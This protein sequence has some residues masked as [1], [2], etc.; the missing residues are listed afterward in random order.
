MKNSELISI[1]IPVYNRE[2]FLPEAI[3]SV[4]QQSAENWELIVV[5]DG[6]EDNTF[7]IAEKFAAQDERIRAIK[8]EREPKGAPV[9]RNIGAEA[10]KGNYLIFL[11][12]DDILAPWCIAQRSKA[13]REY[14]GYDLLAF[15]TLIFRYK[16]DDLRVL[17]NIKTTERELYRFI[18]NDCVWHTMGGIWRKEVFFEIG[19]FDEKLARWQDM[20]LHTRALA[21][22]ISYLYLDEELETPDSFYRVHHENAISQSPKIDEAHIREKFLI[23]KKVEEATKPLNKDKQVFQALRGLSFQVLREAIDHQHIQFCYEFVN[24]AEGRSC[25]AEDVEQILTVIQHYDPDQSV[26]TEHATEAS[27][28]LNKNLMGNYSGSTKIYNDELPLGGDCATEKEHINKLQV[29]NKNAFIESRLEKVGWYSKSYYQDG[30]EEIIINRLPEDGF[31]AVFTSVSTEHINEP[32]LPENCTTVVVD[33]KKEV[34]NKVQADIKVKVRHGMNLNRKFNIGSLFATGTW[35]SF[36]LLDAANING[37]IQ[38]HR[39]LLDKLDVTCL[40]GN[41]HIGRGSEISN[42]L[43]VSNYY[44]KC[45]L[46]NINMSV[47][48]SIFWKCGGFADQ[49]ESLLSGLYLSMNIVDYEYDRRKQVYLPDVQLCFKSNSALRDLISYSEQT[50]VVSRIFK[51][52]PHVTPYMDEYRH[53]SGR[54][55]QVLMRS[56]NGER[57][58]RTDSA[59]DLEKEKYYSEFKRE[60]QAVY[61]GI[62]QYHKDVKVASESN[63]LLRR[64]IHR[65]EK[66]LLLKTTRN[67]FALDYIEDTVTAYEAVLNWALD[68]DKIPEELVWANNVLKQ[69]FEQAGSHPVIDTSRERFENLSDLSGDEVHL[70]PYK[71]QKLDNLQIPGYNEL[72][73]LSLKRRSVR[74]FKQKNVPREILD[75]AL[76]LGFNA[77]T[78]CNRQPFEFRIFDEPNKLTRLTKIPMGTKGYAENIPCLIV[79]IGKMN[80]FFSERDR[81]LIYIDASLAAMGFMYALETLGLS[82]SA[83]NWPDMEPQESA[84]R[85]E[86]KLKPWERVV[87]MMAVGYADDDGLIAYSSKK[88][89]DLIRTYNK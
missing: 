59:T 29:N 43:E 65:L 60:A 18:R 34:L 20:E 32:R 55:D 68:H 35:V 41:I 36:W 8:R 61:Q 85:K 30:I 26:A 19:R 62:N 38:A 67:I 82:S 31:S 24:W 78:A 70:V 12:S 50:D 21:N 74:R 52:R 23:A 49:D 79:I 66:G 87:M 80:A 40:S 51:D 54:S 84:I 48:T 44:P 71:R 88:K 72:Y 63:Y 86:L 11:D 75:K 76:E 42:A 83:I 22:G 53:Y 27:D 5:D 47:K 57:N 37:C 14:A 33:S 25:S 81:H 58:N 13:L 1:I 39:Q 46:H 15:P 2:Q 9:C 69:Y 56:S 28:Y 77:P 7:Q 16:P 3:L 6:S 64:C 73:N 4:Q 89:L 17:W 45:P 10:A